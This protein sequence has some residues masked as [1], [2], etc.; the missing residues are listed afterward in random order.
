[1]QVSSGAPGRV[2]R[3]ALPAEWEISTGVALA[4]IPGRGSRDS[5][6]VLS[7]GCLAD[8]EVQQNLLV[9]SSWI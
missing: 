8:R 4:S 9:A 1:M 5:S 3:S 6:I 7:S 2:T